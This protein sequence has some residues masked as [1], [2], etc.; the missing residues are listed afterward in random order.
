M[1]PEKGRGWQDPARG[2]IRKSQEEMREAKGPTLT[3][4]RDGREVQKGQSQ[5]EPG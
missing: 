4:T 5:L 1:E 3:L 2:T